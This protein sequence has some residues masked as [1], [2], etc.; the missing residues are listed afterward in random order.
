MKYRLVFDFYYDDLQRQ[1]ILLSG[2]YC[3]LPHHPSPKEG[4]HSSKNTWMFTQH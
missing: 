2:N 4:I 1:I 3:K